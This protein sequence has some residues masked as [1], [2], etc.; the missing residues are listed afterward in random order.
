MAVN[1]RIVLGQVDRKI[2]KPIPIDDPALKYRVLGQ[3]NRALDGLNPQ[4]R[5]VVII[6]VRKFLRRRRVVV[7]KDHAKCNAPRLAERVQ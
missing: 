7:S 1:R 4:H 5:T 2:Q 3:A 6:L